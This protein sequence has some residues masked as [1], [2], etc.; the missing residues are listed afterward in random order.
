MSVDSYT[1]CTSSAPS[2]STQST[3]WAPDNDSSQLNSFGGFNF[4]S[5]PDLWKRISFSILWDANF[6]ASSTNG[7]YSIVFPGSNP[8]EAAAVGETGGRGEDNKAQKILSGIT[9]P[10]STIADT[11]DSI[12]KTIQDQYK[13][14]QDTKEDSRIKT[15]EKEVKAQE[16]DLEK[17]GSK[18]LGGKGIFA[19]IKGKENENG[20]Q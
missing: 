8:Q 3:F 12:F 13:E 20:H 2:P 1:S 9:G 14:Q 15:E 10:I 4:T 6:K 7:L 18:G 5:W 17:K 11:V 16:K 19:K